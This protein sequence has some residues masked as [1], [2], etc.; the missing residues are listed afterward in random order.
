MVSDYK[1]NL[2]IIWPKPT[3]FNSC[4][5][6]FM[7]NL[8]ESPPPFLLFVFRLF[9]HQKQKVFILFWEKYFCNMEE[10][11]FFQFC[12]FSFTFRTFGFPGRHKPRYRFVLIANKYIFVPRNLNKMT[13]FIS[14]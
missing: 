5:F 14:P 4:P 2:E 3:L 10:N 9:E 13:C 11:S 1:D 8:G 12:K 6:L 7:E